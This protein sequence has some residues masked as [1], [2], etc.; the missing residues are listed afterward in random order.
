M[1]S[2]R[3][4]LYQNLVNYKLPTSFQLKETYP[5]PPYSTISGMIHRVCEFKEYHPMKISVQGDYYAKV[6]DLN[7]RYEF[8]GGYYENKRRHPVKLHSSKENRDY[9]MV[10][11][12]TTTELLTDVE[13]IIHI[14]PENEEDLITIY[15][16]FK[17]PSEYLSLGRREDIVRIDEVEL[18]QVEEKVLEDVY[19]LDHSA[20]I[21]MSYAEDYDQEDVT[22]YHINRYYEKVQIKKGVEQRRWKKVPVI[23]AANG[24]KIYPGTI[25]FEDQQN[26]CLVFYA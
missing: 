18:V 16:A 12:V 19:I 26:K 24:K 10:R 15:Q 7:T 3:L 22:V 2:I 25:V 17:Q 5:L 11:G 13:L 20:Y 6:N 9:G 23:H 1:Q 21:P 4:K 14:L 8:S